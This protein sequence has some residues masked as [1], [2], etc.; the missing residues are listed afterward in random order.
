M[1]TLK[2]EN[3]DV[4]SIAESGQCF[5]WVK[6]SEE[7][8]R[9]TAFGRIL[10]LKQIPGSDEVTFYCDKTE[11]NAVWGD[12]LDL[13]T[14]YGKIIKSIP[15]DDEYLLKAS[16]YGR[17][18]RIL[19]QDPW[20][21][22]ISFIISQRKN[23]PAIMRSI[24]LISEAAGRYIDKEDGV[25]IYAFPSAEELAQLSM[26]DLKKCS[27]GYRDKYLYSAAKLFTEDKALLEEMKK[28]PDEELFKALTGI[29]GVGKKVA[30]CTMLFGFHR[31]DSFPID[32][33]ME[34]IQRNHYPDGFEVEKY[35][36]YGGV[37]QQY[38]FAYERSIC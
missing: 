24:E 35:R 12:Y 18:I 37:M 27:L 10:H 4:K 36:P 25:K 1:F 32:V 33:W 16:H 34:K 9:I 22:L 17:G 19:N 23:I 30:N 6:I 8:Y 31:L 5:R 21:S 13:K 7:E 2:N 26:D 15:A 20:E 28:M 38:M 11:F 29:F 3:L 14:D